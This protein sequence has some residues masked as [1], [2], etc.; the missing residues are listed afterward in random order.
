MLLIRKKWAR[1]KVIIKLI[2]YKTILVA[3]FQIIWIF[4][5]LKI[6]IEQ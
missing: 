2:Y 1:I 5:I 6:V 4:K 3:S